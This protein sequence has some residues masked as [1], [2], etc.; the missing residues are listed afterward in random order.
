M[1]QI[2][3]FGECFLYVKIDLIIGENGC[4]YPIEIKT[5]NP[6]AS[7]GSTNRLHIFRCPIRLR[8]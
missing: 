1:Y 7:M 5:G 4:L 8:S 2:F 3:A 6:K